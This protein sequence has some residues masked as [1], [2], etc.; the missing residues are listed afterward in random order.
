MT[1]F[2]FE[3][4]KDGT[5]S[6]ALE[7]LEISH[8]IFF[9]ISIQFDEIEHIGVDSLQRNRNKLGFIDKCQKSILGNFPDLSVSI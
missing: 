2:C 7:Y 8:L 3:P 4:L 1:K 9:L 6:I 5:G